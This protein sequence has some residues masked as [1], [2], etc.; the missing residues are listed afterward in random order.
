MGRISQISIEPAPG[1]SGSRILPLDM[2][3]TPL[4]SDAPDPHLATFQKFILSVKQGNLMKKHLN[5]WRQERPQLDS[6]AI[7][8]DD[9]AEDPLPNIEDF[10]N[11]NP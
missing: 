11:G 1:P 9:E 2:E 6:A 4:G 5:A 10:A 7:V 8:S 3:P